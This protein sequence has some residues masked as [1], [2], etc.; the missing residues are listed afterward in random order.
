MIPWVRNVNVQR[1]AMIMRQTTW[2][3]FCSGFV[4]RSWGIV[5]IKR[6]KK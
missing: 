2:D 5:I 3:L 6:K 1:L 4:F